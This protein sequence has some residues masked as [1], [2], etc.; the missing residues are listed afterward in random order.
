MINEIMHYFYEK[1]KPE[2]SEF[3]YHSPFDELMEVDLNQD[4]FHMIFHV[5]GKYFMPLTEGSFSA[6]LQYC[7]DHMVHPDDKE[8]LSASFKE[9]DFQQILHFTD[10]LKPASR[11]FRLLGMDN[12]WTWVEMVVVAGESLQ[13]E[14]GVLRCYIY[15]IQNIVNRDNGIT[16]VRSKNDATRDRLTGLLKGRDF[17]NLANEKLSEVISRRWLMVVIDL[18]NFKLFNDWYGWDKGDMVLARIGAG[19]RLDAQRTGGLAGYLGNDDFCLL[20]PAESLNLEE[21]YGKIHGVLVRYGVSFGFLPCFGV[22]YS[23]AKTTS[24]MSLLDQASM[25]SDIAK[26][27]INQRISFYDPSLAIQTEEEF[28]L[29]SDFQD[30]LKNNEICFY[31]QPQCRASTGKII[32][33]ESLSRWIKKDGSFISPA[34][35]VPV[36]EKYGFVTDLDKYIWEEVCQ[37]IRQW[38]DQGFPMLPISVN[39]SQIDIFTIDVPEYLGSLMDKYDLPRKALKLEITE[40][41]CAEDS[42]KV[43]EVV[44]KLRADGFI[45]LMDDFGSGYS[46]LNM[47]HELEVDIIKLDARFLHLERSN[48]TKGIHII[49]SVVN[50]TKTMGLP[51]IVEGVESKEQNDFL[52]HLGCRYMQGYYFYEP[53]TTADFANLVED[54][55]KIDTSGLSFKPNDEF[56]VREFLDENVYSDSMLNSIL[57]PVAFYS[58]DKKGDVD[59]IRFNEQ[60][61]E[62]VNIPD[63]HK[64]LTGIQKYMPKGEDT[65]LYDTLK[66]AE[67]DRLNGATSVTTFFKSDG[68]FSRFLIHFYYLREEESHKLFYGSARDV[69]KIT[70]LQKQMEVLSRFYSN[71]IIFLTRRSDRYEFEVAAQGLEKEMGLSKEQ[72]EEELNST[73]FYARILPEYREGLLKKCMQAP[74]GVSFSS[75][76]E[77][78]N[79]NGEAVN[80]YI[81]SDYV[82]EETSEVKCIL[83]IARPQEAQ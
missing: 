54:G 68:T 5:E 55:E 32:G 30:A 47:L 43:R 58:L 18:E 3:L 81:R 70:T 71:C 78:L 2:L 31:L 61:Y 24:V 77:M 79:N 76:F 72:L 83:V 62:A 10:D 42:S 56:H 73:K 53:M 75:R 48:E 38:L 66:K 57:G 65:V 21:L 35:F 26:K 12:E 22:T 13:L 17:M 37:W 36:L 28:K 23:D 25:A 69:T 4:Y 41:A 44:R 51:I 15:D 80:L 9:E 52:M 27:D 20:A 19:L 8:S 40:S 46:S 63:F 49:E 14:K 29:L 34:V 64:R 74:L 60:F 7:M 59:I 16:R 67:Q 82:A 39:V 45:V 33:A 50:M 6:F 1:E 11:R